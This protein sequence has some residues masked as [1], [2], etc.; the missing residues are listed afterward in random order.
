MLIYSCLSS[1]MFMMGLYLLPEGVH[2]ALDKE[3]SRFFWQGSNRRQKYHMV[4]WVN[5]C[6]PKD[7]GVWVF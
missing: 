7:Q 1:L 5:L 6:F 2:G 3:M 4:K